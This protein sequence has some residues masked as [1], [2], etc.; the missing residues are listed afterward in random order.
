MKNKKAIYTLLKSQK[1]FLEIP[2]DNML[3]VC[4]YQGGFGSGKTFVG[5]LLGVLLAI[6]YPRMLALSS[7]WLMGAT[8][9]PPWS[10]SEHVHPPAYWG[11]TFRV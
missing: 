1:K 8:E 4:V 11:A 10:I 7:H 9:S 6:K 5:S 3:D 2:H